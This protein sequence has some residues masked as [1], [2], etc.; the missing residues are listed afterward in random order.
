MSIGR[1]THIMS[2]V[3]FKDG[4]HPIDSLKNLSRMKRLRRRSASQRGTTVS[5]KDTLHG[6]ESSS[7]MKTIQ[8]MAVAAPGAMPEVRSST[9]GIDVNEGKKRRNTSQIQDSPKMKFPEET[10]CLKTQW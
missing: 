6:I 8:A 10:R 3:I 5:Q 2:K 1:L 9:H 4:R 7:E